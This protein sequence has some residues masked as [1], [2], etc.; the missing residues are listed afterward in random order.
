MF[1]HVNELSN[2]SVLGSRLMAT[3]VTFTNTGPCS[4]YWL[5]LKMTF[6]LYDATCTQ[7]H[8][9][10]PNNDHTHQILHTVK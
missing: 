5:M 4:K 9:V 7:R 3:I 10:Q 2:N 6:D 8:I 1:S